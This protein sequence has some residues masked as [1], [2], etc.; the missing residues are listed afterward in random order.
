LDTALPL[1]RRAVQRLARGLRIIENAIE[2]DDPEPIVR[3]YDAG[4]NANACGEILALVEIPQVSDVR[5]EV[6]FSP[7][8]ESAEDLGKAPTAEI[9]QARGIA[10]L[11][12]AVS[13]LRYLRYEKQRTITGKVRTLHSL[14]NPSDLFSISGLQAIVVEW[15]SEEFGKRNV[16]VLL[17]PEEYLAA[18]E[19]RRLGRTISVFGDLEQG[20]QW[21]LNN[22]R[23]FRLL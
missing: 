8:W 10:V 4:L 7:E 23:D 2:K 22:A 14:K 16:T 3:G 5:F 9:R 1:E 6:V 11:K 15:D 20:R 17:G 19:A 13:K 21:S 18:V 12:E